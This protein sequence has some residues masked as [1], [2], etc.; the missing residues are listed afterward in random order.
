MRGGYIPERLLM[1]NQVY[2][3]VSEEPAYSPDI[4]DYIYPTIVQDN[5]MASAV[6][7]L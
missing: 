4:R 3:W 2:Q 5:A 1:V 7:R 6:G